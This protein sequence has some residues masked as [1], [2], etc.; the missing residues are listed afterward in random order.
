[1]WIVVMDIIAT[2]LL[3]LTE[4]GKVK[5]ERLES[6]SVGSGA[7]RQFNFKHNFTR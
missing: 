3:L 2:I 4:P 1:M 5:V 7:D 6:D